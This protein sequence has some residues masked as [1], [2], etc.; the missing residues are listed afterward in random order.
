M[1]TKKNPEDLRHGKLVNC[2]CHEVAGFEAMYRKFECF[3]YT[4][5]FQK[6]V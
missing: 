5:N 2:A 1:T 4:L 3:E 6:V